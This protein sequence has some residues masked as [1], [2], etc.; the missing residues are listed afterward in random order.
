MKGQNLSLL[1]A[2]FRLYIVSYSIF[3]EVNTQKPNYFS[4][5]EV[6][7]PFARFNNVD[8]LL[9]PEMKSTGEVMGI[10]KTFE[11]AFAKAQIASGSKLPTDG[12]VFISVKDS[13]KKHAIDL[14]KTLIE[15]GFKIV[16]TRGTAKFLMEN[17]VPTTIVNKVTEDQPHVVDMIARKEINLVI[18]TTEGA[19]ATKDSFSIRRTSLMRGV[20]YTTT[21]S[22]AYALVDAIWAYKKQDC[23]FEVFALQDIHQ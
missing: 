20:T 1:P 13:D 9:G 2:F 21:I 11:M 19:Q 4:V 16:A 3:E 7:F 23:K 6:V 17:D 14:A 8:T 22:G 18:N 5:K 10:D 12:L 15:I